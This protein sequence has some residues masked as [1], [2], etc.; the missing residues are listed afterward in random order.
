MINLKSSELPSNNGP[1]TGNHARCSQFTT[2]ICSAIFYYKVENSSNDVKFIYSEKATKVC[3]I[4]T[5]DL[6]GNYIGQIYG[7]DLAK[8]CSLL[9]I[10]EL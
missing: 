3:E 6:T 2:F 1:K 4:S 9:R 10:Y 5:V 8:F 7:G